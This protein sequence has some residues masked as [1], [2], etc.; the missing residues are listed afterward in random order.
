LIPK[1]IEL[2]CELVPQAA[3]IALLVDLKNE[4]AEEH[5]RTT[6]EA[7]RAKGVKVAVLKASTEAE[8][9][10]SFAAI[11][12]VRAGGLLVA[13]D[14]FFSRRRAQFVALAAQHAVPV[15]YW[16]PVFVAAGG[17]IGYGTDTDVLFRQAG[18]YAGRILKGEKPAALPVQQPTTF[19]LVVNLKTAKALGLTVPPSIL[20]RADEVIE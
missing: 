13:A 11:Q 17:L 5:V 3:V 10:A 9:D 6:Q 15:I 7:A 2:L 1:R 16:N 18:I 19:K 12:Q 8:I 14:S 4:M 20:A